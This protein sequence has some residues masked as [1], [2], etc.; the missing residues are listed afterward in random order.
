METASITPTGGNFWSVGAAGGAPRVVAKDAGSATI[1]PDGKTLVFVRGTVGSS[2]LW[3]ASPPDADPRQYRQPP[4]VGNRAHIAPPQFSPDGSKL[5]V[6]TSPR[7]ATT[8]PELWLV[9]FP[10]GLPV[11]SPV[12]IPARQGGNQRTSWMPDSRRI[13]LSA[14][15]HLYLADT[16]GGALRQLTAT[17]GEEW[18]PTVSPDGRRLAFA[19][20]SSDFDI[21]EIALPNGSIHT[22]LAT[23]RGEWGATWSP[24]GTQFAYITDAS[25]SPQIWLR[26]AQAEEGAR[27]LVQQGATPVWPELEHPR[28]SPDGRRIAYDIY[29]DRHA[30]AISSVAGGQPVILD[31]ESPDHHGASWSPDGN[32][33]AY[34][35]LNGAKWE[36]VKRPLGGGQPVVLEDAEAGGSETDWSRS[37]EWICHMRRGSLRLVRQT[38]R[39]MPKPRVPEITALGFS[40]D[41]TTVY[42]LRRNPARHWELASFSVPGAQLKQ[43]VALDIPVSAAVNFLSV[44]PDGKR[45]IT[46][47]GRRRYDIWLLEGFSER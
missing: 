20:G 37:G 3:I 21:V 38:A 23:S 34:R 35:R 40:P 33:I 32:W 1:S 15:G 41:S 25:G 36:L 26:S 46:S 45:L 5:A 31:Q 8:E 28:F 24:T 44:H 6:I 22:L 42:A 2:T 4:F 11:H 27:P 47:V 9:P 13:V 12:R 19:S 30:V 29:G 39:V 16:R 10:S 14:S 17:T 7:A 18:Q 43:V